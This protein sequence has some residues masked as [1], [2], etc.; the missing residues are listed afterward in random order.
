[1]NL[2][3][4]IA[5]AGISGGGV[6]AEIGNALWQSTTWSTSCKPTEAEIRK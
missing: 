6:T 2:I 4:L 3:A 5:A 1:M